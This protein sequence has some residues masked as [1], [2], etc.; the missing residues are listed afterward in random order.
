MTLP[1]DI[2]GARRAFGPVQALDG[3]D[4]SVEPGQFVGLIGPNGSGKSTLI[5][6][7]LGMVRLDSGTSA[8]FGH[9][10]G[11]PAGK[12]R[13]GYL[14]EFFFSPDFLTPWAYVE[15]MGALYGLDRRSSYRAAG[16]LIERL[17]LLEHVHRPAGKLS[18]GLLRRMGIVVS[19]F[20]DPD[21]LVYDEPAWGLDPFGRKALEDLL[22]ELHAAGKSMMLS[23]HNME[24]VEKVCDR[25]VFISEGR[26]RGES[27]AE[28]LVSHETV[29]ILCAAE[30]QPTV[31]ATLEP[32]GEGRWV[33]TVGE[34]ER[35]KTLTALLSQGAKVLAVAPQKT[36]LIDWVVSAHGDHEGKR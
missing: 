13:I 21:L 8:L 14:P 26:V 17:G 2:H 15:E 6:G 10:P 3:I 12:A 35:E 7:L 32:A 36:E 29:R 16:P 11:R 22:L 9:L 30:K 1:V 31:A 5:G 28:A 4:F 24:M 34:A 27:T 18:K 20:H 19:L 25:Y 23:S 33:A